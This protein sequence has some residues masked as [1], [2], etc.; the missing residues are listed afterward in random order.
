MSAKRPSLAESMKLS[1]Q[2][3]AIAPLPPAQ[4]QDSA[5]KP[6][7][8]AAPAPFASA[9]ATGFYAATRAGKK[10]VTAAV[11]P[12]M[13]KQLKTLAVTMETTTEA[14]LLEAIAD[15]FVKYG[16]SHN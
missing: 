6:E 1:A 11:E 3:E 12:A 14:L 4:I 16:L 5:P 15:L 9:R 13:H 2:T 8:T 10:K 7:R